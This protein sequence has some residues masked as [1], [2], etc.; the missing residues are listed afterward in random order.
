MET[1]EDLEEFLSQATQ[2]G[3]RDRLLDRGIAWAIMRQVGHL[4]EDAPAFGPAIDTDL[5]DYGFS[6]L[7]A[8]LRL[9]EVA[10]SAEISRGAFEKAANAFESLVRN[11]SPDALERGFYRVIAGAAYHLAGFSAIAY[12]LFNQR[13]TGLNA[14][15]AEDALIFLIL[16]DLDALRSHTRDWLLDETHSDQ[17]LGTSF[18]KGELEQ[19]ELVAIVLNST[20]CRALAHFDFAL[21]T[22]EASLL[23]TARVLLSDAVKLATDEGAVPLWWIARLCLNLIDDLWQH[24]LDVNLPSVP[25]RGE[26]KSTRPF[27][28]CSLLPCMDAKP[29][30]SSSGRPN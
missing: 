14:N 26:R 17:N 5:A 18:A 6:L 2:P 16:R 30:R 12:S 29:P 10:G 8:G 1:I 15:P 23:D 13:V 3:V 20:I 25:P 19:E 21:Q 24:S 9:K 7:R 28:D 4:P 22:G 27:G 11:G